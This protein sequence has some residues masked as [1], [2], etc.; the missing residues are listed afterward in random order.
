MCLYILV[1]VY[2]AYVC[3]VMCAC[4]EVC[5]CARVCVCVYVCVCGSYPSSMIPLA[6][7]HFVFSPLYTALLTEQNEKQLYNQF[8][9]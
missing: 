1:C 6:S 5:L 4:S 8:N 7:I 3:G 2:I 9:Q